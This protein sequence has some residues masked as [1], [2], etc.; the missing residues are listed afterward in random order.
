MTVDKRWDGLTESGELAVGV[1]FAGSRHKSFTLRVPM[2]GDLVGAQQDNPQGPL[3]LITVDVFRRQLLALGDIPAASLTTELLLDELT[4]T[5]LA[6]LGRADEVLEKKLAPPSA[7][8]TTG[9]VSNTPL[10]D[11]AIA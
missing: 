1:Y 7:V 6:L 10:S 11:T 5:D 2:A 4:E 9:D 3:Q 8:P